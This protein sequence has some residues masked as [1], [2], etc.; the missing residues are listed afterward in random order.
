MTED[1]NVSVL[2]GRLTKDAELKPHPELAVG[3]FTIAVN[4]KKRKATG[5]HVEE[6]SYIDINVYGN[7][8]EIITPSLKKGVQVS[9]VGSLKQDRWTDQ[10][11]KQNKSRLVVT[12]NSIQILGGTNV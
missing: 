1:T 12:A 4:R 8:A 6:P 9:I 5:K 10:S 7:Y 3:Y 11:T 2:V